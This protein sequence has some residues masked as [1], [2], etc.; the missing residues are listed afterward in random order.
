MRIPTP[1]ISKPTSPLHEFL[2]GARDQLP[3]LIGVAPFGM[4]FGAL[5]LTA[6]IPPLEA[7]GFSLFV[8]AGSAQFIATG[9]IADGVPPLII[10][11]TIMVVNLRHLLYSATFSSYFQHLPARWKAALAWLLTDEAFVVA[12]I[13]YQRS[14]T[15]LAHW[16][17]FGTGLAL[18]VAWQLS[19]AI[20][21]LLGAYIPANWSLDFALPLTFMALITPTL[22]DRPA[23]AA[24]L[25]A[26]VLA[27]V[28]AGLPYKLG[29][30]L[31]ASLGIGVGLMMEVSRSFK[32]GMAERNG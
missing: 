19:T 31:A 1:P 16:Y 8:F 25:T 28:L 4:I 27:V 14:D 12:S 23:W 9:L 26:G 22:S 21:I 10:V 2:A 5:A 24:A 29:L 13:R 15:V 18:W 17:T 11:L 32:T 20:G 30:L 3:L 6:G 7:Q